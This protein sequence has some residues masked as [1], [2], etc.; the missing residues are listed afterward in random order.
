MNDDVLGL[1]LLYEFME[2]GRLAVPNFA[3]C[4]ID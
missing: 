4:F 2:V 1:K 3:V